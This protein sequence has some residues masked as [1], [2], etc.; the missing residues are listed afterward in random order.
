[1]EELENLIAK[2]GK[3]AGN[4]V[5]IDG[6]AIALIGYTT[7]C[8]RKAKWS[9]KDI[10]KFQQIALSGNYQNVIFTCVSVLNFEDESEGDLC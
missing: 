6:N 5:G 7:Q 2:N 1:M 8:L 10:E 9:R 3:G 4:L